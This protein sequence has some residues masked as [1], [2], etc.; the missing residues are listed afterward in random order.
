MS[1]S[2]RPWPV[3]DVRAGGCLKYCGALTSGLHEVQ[4]HVDSIVPE[5][6]VTLDPALLC[7]DVIILT[8]EVARDLA[9]GGFVVDAITKAWGVNN[10]QRN[11]RTLLIQLQ[12]NGHWLDLD[13]LLKVCGGWVVGIE[14]GEDLAAAKS[15]DEGGAAGT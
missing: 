10:G 14:R 11:P 2:R 15:V 8:L 1:S 4:K 9:E 13:A 5:A 6:R 3:K 12:L 7:Q